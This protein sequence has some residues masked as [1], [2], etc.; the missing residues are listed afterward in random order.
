MDFMDFVLPGWRLWSHGS[1]TFHR[2][3]ATLGDTWMVWERV[4]SLRHLPGGGGV[5]L[6]LQC[7]FL[8][9]LFVFL[10]F[11]RGE[12]G[13]RVGGCFFWVGEGGQVGHYLLRFSSLNLYNRFHPFSK[14]TIAYHRMAFQWKMVSWDCLERKWWKMVIIWAVTPPSNSHHQDYYIFSRA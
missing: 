8:V 11:F 12:R 13:G 10:C 7:C 2:C 1:W 3:G 9:F 14:Q 5:T 4:T 6:A